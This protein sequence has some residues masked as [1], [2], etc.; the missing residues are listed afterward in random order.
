MTQVLLKLFVEFFS[1]GIFSYGGGLAILVLLQEK[2]IELRWLTQ[3][4][5]ADIVAISQSTPGPIAINLATFVGYTQGSILGSFIASIAVILPGTI[6]SIIVAKFMDKFNEKP[7]VK[8]ILKGLRAIVIGMIATAI[9]N[10]AYVSIVNIDAY[11]VTRYFWDL[12]ELKSLIVFSILIF[13]S[14]KFK[15][16]PIYY[17]VPAGIIGLFLW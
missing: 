2:A 13:L 14:I 10:I 15:K 8:A 9:L 12:V 1:L 17:I 11:L 7:V 16:H 6:I 4:Q 5:F 3:A